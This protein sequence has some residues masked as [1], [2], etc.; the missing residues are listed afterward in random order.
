MRKLDCVYVFALGFIALIQ[1]E[2]TTLESVWLKDVTT[3][4][5]TDK[6][7]LSDIIFPKELEFQLRRSS[8]TRS[9]Y[10]R[11][12]YDIYPNASFY[13]VTKLKDGETAL[14]KSPI[15]ETE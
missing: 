4:S 14:V 8:E 11:R 1:S 7:T 10:L 2:S 13:F 3:R 9:L 15:R 5:L 12:N 6:R